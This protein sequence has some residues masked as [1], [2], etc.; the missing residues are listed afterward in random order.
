MCVDAPLQPRWVVEAFARVAASDF[1]VLA[2]LAIAG[3]AG[4]PLPRLLAAYRALDRLAF[5]REPA[6]PLALAEHVPH[7]RCVAS[8]SAAELAALDLDVVFA[9]GALDDSRLDGVARYGVWRFCFGADGT[10][11]EAL[12]GYREVAG[13]EPLTC[14]GLKI[15]LAPGAAP[16]LACESW[17]RTVALSVGR[18]RAQLLHKSAEFA[19]RALRELHRA[20]HDWLQSCRE[21]EPASRVRQAPDNAR[22]LREVAGIGGRIMRRALEHASC[23]EQWFLAFRFDRPGQ[24]SVPADLAGF[25]P[26]VPPKDRDWADPFVLQKDGRYYVFFEELPFASRKGHISMIEIERSG[27]RS[28]PVRVLERDYHLSYPFLLEHDTA[29]FMVPE[30]AQNRTVEAYRCVDFPRHWR[31]EKVLLEGVRAVDATFHPAANRWWMFANVAAGQSRAF[32]DELHLFHAERFLGE[33][34]PHVRNPVK[35]DVRSARPA[36]RL[37]SRDGI[38]YRPAQI[39]V[40]RYGSGL[41]IHRVERLTREE[42]VETQVERILPALGQSLLGI[43]TVNHAAGLTVVDA[44][45]RRRRIGDATGSGR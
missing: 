25:T 36:G 43:H 19:Y 5:G 33:W 3:K 17:G 8:V 14:S 12:A 27:R 21:L 31:L 44:F 40:P 11:E 7:E 29:L 26:I 45:T 42:Y 38:L 18:N 20:G 30:S 6:E 39:C 15:R 10:E 4:A 22:L 24:S 13:G 2:V 34:Q 41:A 28:E 32:D 16:R 23:V 9:I 1:A 37:Y 35:S